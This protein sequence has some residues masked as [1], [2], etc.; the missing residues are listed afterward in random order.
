MAK[1]EDRQL[2]RFYGVLPLTK[3]PLQFP[4]ASEHDETAIHRDG[5][6]SYIACGIAREPQDGIRNFF[7]A[8]NASHGDALLHCLESFTLSAR[9]HLIGH[10]RP[11][12]PWAY[13]VDANAACRVFE[14]RALREPYDSVLRGVIDSPLCT[15]K[16]PSKRRAIDDGT[17]ALFAHLLQL[18]F[19]AAPHT[20]QIDAHHPV[21]IF[22]GGIGR[23]CKN[24]LNAGVVVGRIESAESGDRLF[25]HGV[26]L[27]VV[28]HVAADG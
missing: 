6:A 22:A 12:Q 10:R 23:F 17:A 4:F 2:R 24:V 26:Y 14:S 7:G 21:I 9:D 5:L 20:A 3:L 16:A 28:R 1:Y 15:A 8:A 13:S 19:H 27:R 11:D 18:E 25:H